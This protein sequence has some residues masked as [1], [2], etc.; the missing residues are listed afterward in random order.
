VRLPVAIEGT[1][2]SVEALKKAEKDEAWI[3]RV[4][5]NRGLGTSGALRATSPGAKVCTTDLLEWNDG[6]AEVVGEGLQF[7]L[8]PFEIRTFK[9]RVKN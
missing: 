3:V 1:G 5:E 4:V 6:P 2:F 8:K 7:T 9:L